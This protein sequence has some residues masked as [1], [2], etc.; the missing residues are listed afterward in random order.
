MYGVEAE[1]LDEFEEEE[2]TDMVSLKRAAELYAN[3]GT[4]NKIRLKAVTAE[5]D[6]KIVFE[7]VDEHHKL[8]N[9]D[10]IDREDHYDIRLE[11]T[12]KRSDIEDGERTVKGSFALVQSDHNEN[13]WTAIT[14]Y[15]SDFFERGVL[16]LFNKS[17]PNI[18]SFFL[19]TSE[20]EEIL[21]NIEENLEK[22]VIVEDSVTYNYQGEG[23]ESHETH[24]FRHIFSE[25]DEEQEYLDKLVFK[26]GQR[27]DNEDYFEGYLTR[28]GQMKFIGGNI[29]PFFEKLVTQVEATAEQRREL[30]EE[31]IDSAKEG[32]YEKVHIKFEE[33]VFQGGVKNHK[34]INA[35]SQMSKS[36][37]TVFHSNPYLHMSMLD[38]RDGSS[39]DIFVTDDDLVKIALGHRG[40][41]SSLMR[42]AEHISSHFK[43][44][45]I[46]PGR[47][48]TY[49][50][51]DFF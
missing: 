21:H 23:D 40:T 16:Y 9:V 17:N 11:R 22:S 4:Y 51:D 19:S 50:F 35:L 36:S 41:S 42:V 43:Q 30:F 29:T 39:F 18:Y 26:V 14:G 15:E 24:P 27:A 5:E 6:P 38:Y 49:N 13:I 47:E 45:D 1:S 48:E 8:M 28:D 33:P 12:I 37:I 46:L 32:N 31:K 34:L 25:I 7:E 3:G 44:G 10:V 20:I 2:I